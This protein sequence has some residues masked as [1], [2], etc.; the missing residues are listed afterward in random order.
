ML[1][2]EIALKNNHYY[3]YKICALNLVDV[4]ICLYDDAICDA[5]ECRNVEALHSLGE[6]FS[7]QL[8]DDVKPKLSQEADAPKPPKK[9]RQ[10]TRIFIP[11]LVSVQYL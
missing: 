10:P 2:G 4:R 7:D 8:E 5:D 11:A 3:Y 9:E 6:T 1:S